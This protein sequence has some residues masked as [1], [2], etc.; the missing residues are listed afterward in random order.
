M[1]VQLNEV[2]EHIAVLRVSR[3]RVRNALD[4]AAMEAFAAAVEQAHASEDLRALIL[5]GAGD[6]FIAGGDL[7][8]LHGASGEEDGWRLT[9]LMTDA[10]NRLEML[11]CPVIAALN[12]PARGG[13]AE[14]ALACDLRVAAENADLSFAQITLGLTPGW[15]G[16]QRLLR[17]VGYSRAL[18][19]LSTGQVLTASEMLA[20]GLV[21]RVAPAGEAL[22]VALELAGRITQYAPEA[23]RAVKRLLRAGL[24]LPPALAASQEQRLFPPLWASPVHHQAVARWLE[25]K[26]PAA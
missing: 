20:Y 3:P 13:G 1:V 24:D 4:W 14:I 25:R 23:V 16:G 9:S 10:L 8:A 6:V 21:N 2:S 17:L 19:W 18:E 11:P 22:S 7:R 15:G 12:G 5:T 26:K